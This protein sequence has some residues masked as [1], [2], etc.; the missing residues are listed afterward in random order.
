MLLLLTQSQGQSPSPHYFLRD[1]SLLN[2]EEEE[3]EEKKTVQ[4]QQQQLNS[5]RNFNKYKYLG[6]F[7]YASPSTVSP[8]HNITYTHT[9]NRRVMEPSSRWDEEVPPYRAIF[10]GDSQ[11]SPYFY[12]NAMRMSLSFFFIHFVPWIERRFCPISSPTAPPQPNAKKNRNRNSFPTFYP[13]KRMLVFFSFSFSFSLS[14][15]TSSSH[16]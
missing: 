11:I 15:S 10:I 7:F 6:L 1:R 2:K 12:L 4:L 16:K 5:H 9:R 3:E 13:Q 14:L 8:L